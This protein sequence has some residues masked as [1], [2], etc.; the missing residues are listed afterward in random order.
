M[1]SMRGCKSLTPVLHC[2]MTLLNHL[3]T[4][5]L[6]LIFVF[7]CASSSI[8]VP[9]TDASIAADADPVDSEPTDLTRVDLTAE[10][11]TVLYDGFGN[12]EF[13]AN[14]ILMEPKAA[15]ASSE[16]HAA[17][18]LLRDS[19]NRPVKDFEV[20]V[21]AQTVRQIRATAP[22]PWEVL[23]IFFNY[24]SAPV[25]KTTNYF[26]FK[27]NGLELGRAFDEVG[28]YFLNFSTPAPAVLSVG[29]TYTYRLVKVAGQLSVWIDDVLVLE[30]SGADFPD[31][32]Y[33]EAGSLGLYTE[34]AAVR[35]QSVEW[36]SLD[37]EGVTP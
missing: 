8:T 31:A 33:D 2:L 5:F 13:N 21:V 3:F 10:S 35:I 1:R 37:G 15:V 22:N 19:V 27:P 28:Q 32:I 30:F 7:G 12:I 26:I 4:L 34:D 18:I 24:N 17:L 20:R 6:T 9:E 14:E 25:G 36:R 29:Q 23:W 11:W 16:T